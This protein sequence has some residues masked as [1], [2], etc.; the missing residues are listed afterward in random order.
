MKDTRERLLEQ[1][2]RV[3]GAGEPWALTLQTV[4]EAYVI[5]GELGE[6]KKMLAQALEQLQQVYGENSEPVGKLLVD[7][8]D[9]H[10]ASK[11]VAD[12][13][14]LQERAL[15]LFERYHGAES[16]LTGH[17]CMSMAISYYTEEGG[18]GTKGIAAVE[19]AM[20]I[21]ERK[22]ERTGKS[23]AELE[24]AA[25]QLAATKIARDGE[26]HDDPRMLNVLRTIWESLFRCRGVIVQ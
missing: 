13:L 21:T 2:Q 10:D 25:R 16:C 6:A 23:M 9:A 15:P 18:W 4:G 22:Y 14:A 1:T 17:L 8:A 12:R 3:H 24:E 19:R 20:S 5:I 7:L 26:V 11:E